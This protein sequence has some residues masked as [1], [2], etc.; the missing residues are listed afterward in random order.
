MADHIGRGSEPDRPIRRAVAIAGA[1]GD[2]FL[3]VGGAAL[4][5]GIL[6][7]GMYSTLLMLVS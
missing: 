4:G 6:L 1:A 5:A 2:W 3:V 7:G